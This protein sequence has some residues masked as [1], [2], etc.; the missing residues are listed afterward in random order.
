[1]N[2]SKDAPIDDYD[3][4]PRWGRYNISGWYY[5]RE[6][7][8]SWGVDISELSVYNDGAEIS[9]ETC[10]KIADAIE[11]NAA[12]LDDRHR[13]WLKGHIPLWRSCGGYAQF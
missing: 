6:K 11:A 2:P 1:M 3:G 9:A 13:D 4:E 8:N 5:L 7:L 10:G 12:A